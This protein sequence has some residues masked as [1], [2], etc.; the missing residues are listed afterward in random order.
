MLV[1]VDGGRPGTS[2]GMTSFELA[3]AMVR[4]GCVLAAGLVSG[5][6]AGMAFDGTLLSQPARG[7]QPVTDA[8]LLVYR[9]VYVAPLQPV[10]SPDGDGVADTIRLSYKTISTA[11]VTATLTGPDGV[12]RLT[13]Q[14]ARVAQRYSL[15]WNG[16]RQGTPDGEGTYR[17]TVTA[18]DDQGRPSSME[19][20]FTLNRT[21]ARL[22]AAAVL[23]TGPGT[24][25]PLAAFD[26]TR[27]ATI[28][29]T[30]LSPLGVPAATLRTT[31]PAPGQQAITWDGKDVNGTA[32]PPGRYTVSV[33]ATNDAGTVTRTATLVVRRA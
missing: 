13:D 22:K 19:R 8:L 1:T 5:P 6:Q 4:Q 28:A 7:E 3:Q 12:V 25:Q 27:A 17:W 24:P 16:L 10:L 2:V 11:Q 21:L 15:T 26:T 14:G 18:T 33:T 20:T 30:I 23:R 29:V 31:S 9:G 32:V